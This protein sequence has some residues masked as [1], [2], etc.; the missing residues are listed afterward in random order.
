MNI[1][2]QS[3]YILKNN[4]T[5][6]FL[7]VMHMDWHYEEG[8]FA[9]AYLDGTIKLGWSNKENKMITVKAHENSVLSLQW[10][11]R[12]V[13]LASISSDLTCKIWKLYESELVHVYTLAQ[14]YEPISVTWSPVVGN[15]NETLLLAVGSNFGTVSVWKIPK[16]HG[17]RSVPELVIN[18]QGH[19]YNSVTS[20]SID[21][22]G[23]LLASGCLKGPTGVVNIWSLHDGSLVQTIT[24]SGGINPCGIC[25]LNTFNDLTIA[26]SRSKSICVVKYSLKDLS[27][28]LPLAAVRCSL[29]RKGIRDLKSAPFFKLF[30]AV[31]PNILL[32]QYNNEKM[33]IQTGAHLMH[34]MYLKSLASLAILLELNK[35]V[36]Y[37][38]CPFNCKEQSDLIP[39]FL[40]LHTL[41]LATRMADSLIRR[42]EL[43]EVDLNQ[44]VESDTKCTATRDIFWTIK[45][46]Q[47]IIQWV[48]QRP[49]DWQIG[50]KCKAFL[51]GSDRHGQLAELGYSSSV[52]TQVE[53]F[54]TARKIVCGQNCTFVIEANGTVLAC[55]EGS[56]GRLGHGN[57]DDLHSLSVISSL[58]GFV[59]TDLATSVGSD[60]HSLALAESGEVFSWG[61]GD[62]GK[63]LKFEASFL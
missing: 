22:T 45:Q 3:A 48:S 5:I 28:N 56:Y 62:Y 41:T 4:W 40:W 55:G 14:T 24:G 13:F 53:T 27:N 35:V 36:C 49:Q 6:I 8:P 31:L 63:C 29:I 61:D 59:I 54:S 11:P 30:I 1:L 51:W 50:G 2:N 37:K 39:E 18:S 42:I 47:Q 23:L 20:I 19:A 33:A 57:S 16:E 60:G 9:I 38:L 10:D 32:E 26:F 17:E 15:N 7:A 58:Q 52:P 46:D 34:T 25:W 44:V 21:H 12:G 43:P